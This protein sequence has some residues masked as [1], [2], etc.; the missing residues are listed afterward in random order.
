M[1][2]GFRCYDWSLQTAA[3]VTSEVGQLTAEASQAVQVLDASV[4]AKGFWDEM[5]Q[6]VWTIVFGGFESPTEVLREHVRAV[7]GLP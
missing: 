5:K 1:L 6:F 3:G 4:A 2:S 7:E